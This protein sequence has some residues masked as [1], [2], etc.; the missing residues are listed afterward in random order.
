MTRF[1][2]EFFF[3]LELPFQQEY[4]YFFRMVITM[5]HYYPICLAVHHSKVA[6]ICA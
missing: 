4:C 3:S 5:G 6:Q 1:Q 2:T